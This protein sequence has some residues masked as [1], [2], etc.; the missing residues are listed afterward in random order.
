MTKQ[1]IRN[2]IVK[3]AYVRVFNSKTSIWYLEVRR[4]VLY[5]GF[6]HYKKSGQVRELKWKDWLRFKHRFHLFKEISI[7]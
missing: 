5:G 7:T 2:N 4:N 1:Q 6:I 3:M